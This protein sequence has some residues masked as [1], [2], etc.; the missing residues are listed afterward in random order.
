MASVGLNFANITPDNGAVRELSRLVFLEVLQA[1]RIGTLLDIHRNVYNGDKL[2]LVGEFG[3]LGK[4]G[5]GCSPEYGND[6]INTAE[7]VWD[8]KAWEIAEQLCYKDIEDTLV[9]YT[10]ESGTNIGDLTANDYLDEIIVPRLELAI[11]KMYIRLAFFGDKAAENVSDGGI[12]KNGVDT[13]YFTLI[14]GIFKQLYAGVTAGT[15]KRVTIAANSEATIADQINAINSQAVDVLDDMIAM[16]SPRLRQAS[17]PVVLVTQS[18]ATG[19]ESQLLKTYYGSE[20]QWQSLFAGIRET[21]YR[22]IKL[23]VVPMFD[24]IIQSYEGNGNAYNLPHRAIYTTEQNLAL[25]VN[26]TDEF[27]EL[28]IFFDRTTRLNHIYATDKMGAM[29]ID[30]S[31]AVIAY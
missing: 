6:A 25:G 16:A 1:D 17:N 15:T 18:F 23:R 20:L 22:G 2:G 3:L 30:E 29:V 9:K 7:K 5:V 27:A 8:I 4:A 24:E 12:I 26:G 28:D 14:N 31:M 10:L 19:F 11:M 21:T 13:S